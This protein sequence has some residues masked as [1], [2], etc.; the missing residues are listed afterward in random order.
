[1][2]RTEIWWNATVRGVVLGEPRWAL[3]AEH[4]DDLEEAL[5]YFAGSVKEQGA[6]KELRV[7]QIVGE[8]QPNVICAN[9]PRGFEIGE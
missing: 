1:M 8:G 3:N 6:L 4:G 5:A 9:T 2:Y 7:V